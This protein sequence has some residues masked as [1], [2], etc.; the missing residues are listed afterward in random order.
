MKNKGCWILLALFVAWAGR[1]GRAQE[2]ADPPEPKDFGVQDEGISVVGFEE[3]SP[4]FSSIGY[5]DDTNTG[6]RWTTSGGLLMTA[7]MNMIPHGAVLTEVR[8]YLRDSNANDNFNGAVCRY[9][10]DANSGGTPNVG[11]PVFLQSAG[12]PGDSV[13]TATPDLPILYQ[14][15]R[16][17]DGDSDVVH[18]T[19]QV[20]TPGFDGSTRIRQVRLRW[21]R[22]I[23]PAPAL[24]TFG[25]VPMNHQFFQHIEALVASGITVGCGGGNY[26]PDQAVNRGQMAAFLARALGLHWPWDAQ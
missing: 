17:G 1:P 19:L 22:R 12:T 10:A 21:R 3:F 26:C 15:D 20:E 6:G 13:L 8:F 25:D 11:C 23:S 5:A 7:P 16:D 9:W 18:Y 2:L 14:E 4:E 24:A